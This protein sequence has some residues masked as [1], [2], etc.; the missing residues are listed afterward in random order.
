MYDTAKLSCV[1][2]KFVFWFVHEGRQAIKKV[3]K[4]VFLSSMRKLVNLLLLGNK[5]KPGLVRMSIAEIIK[6][7]NW[8][9]PKRGNGAEMFVSKQPNQKR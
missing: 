2:K 9:K 8:R 4:K 6:N 7:Q 3:V 5:L 1:S